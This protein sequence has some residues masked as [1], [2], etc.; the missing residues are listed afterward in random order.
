MQD[1]A[2]CKWA[3]SGLVQ[4]AG[5]WRGEAKKESWKHLVS[6]NHSNPICH[7]AFTSPTSACAYVAR[8]WMVEL[9]V[10]P[11]WTMS[12]ALSRKRSRLEIDEDAEDAHRRR[13]PSPAL[14]A[15]SDTLKKSRT[16]HR[17]SAG[18]MSWM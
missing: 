9:Q 15:L 4:M 14:S 7:V 13:D 5:Q 16:Y 2:R 3:R 17:G 6:D 12:V 1:D 11:C 18:S 10:L 8:Y